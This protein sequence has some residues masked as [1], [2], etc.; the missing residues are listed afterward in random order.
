[1]SFKSHEW[2]IIGRVLLAG[3]LSEHK[4]FIGSIFS[5]AEFS[6]IDYMKELVTSAFTMHNGH[7]RL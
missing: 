1:M 5:T 6:S 4:Q 2:E 3:H 7:R